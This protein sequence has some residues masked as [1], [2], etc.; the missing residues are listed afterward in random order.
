LQSKAEAPLIEHTIVDDGY[1]VVGLDFPFQFYG[2]TYTTTLMFANGVVGLLAPENYNWG[3]CCNGED[4]DQFTNYGSRLDFTLMPFHTDLISINGVGKFYTQ[5]DENSM[6]YMW[7]NLQ[8]YYRPGSLNDFDMTI[9]PLGNIEMS[10]RR[11]DIQ[12][13]SVTVGV[14]N[15]LSEGEYIQWFYHSRQD[16]VIYWDSSTDTPIEVENQ[17]IC[18]AVPDSHLSCAWYPQNYAENFLAA[19]CE[20]DS[21]YSEA[22]PNFE[23]AWLDQQCESNN[24]YSPYC[25]GYTEPI[26]EET[27]EEVEATFEIIP[28]TYIEIDL[29]PSLGDY[30]ID[31]N[32]EIETDMDSFEEVEMSI[33]EFEAEIEAELEA[34]VELEIEEPIE[35][36]IEE[37]VIEEEVIEE[38]VIEE[39]V[40]EPGPQESE[41]EEPEEVES[42]IMLAEAEPEKPKKSK[43]QIKNDK[44]NQIVAIKLAKIHEQRAVAGTLEEQASLEALIIALMNFNAGYKDYSGFLPDGVGYESTDIYMDSFIPDNKRGLRVGLAQELQFKKMVDLQWQN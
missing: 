29:I 11:L 16:G 33:E 35:E 20:K 1:A 12:N 34:L 17:S 26:I 42:E 24:Q 44:L 21:L 7:K 3:L 19:E 8:E 13:H 32:I 4:L 39:P 25:P 18:E 40:E 36:V 31:L 30:S 28:E 9:Y 15:D 14:V 10:Y 43:E 38:E 5:G 23:T 37:E 41:S 22:C 6:K 27:Y 2:N